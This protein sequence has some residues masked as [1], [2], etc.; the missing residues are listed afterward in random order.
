M[1]AWRQPLRIA[2]VLFVCGV[3]AAVVFGLR[4]RVETAPPAVVERSDPDAVIQTRGSRLVQADADGENLR[5]VS[6]IQ[7]T[8]PDGRLRLIG[9]V[10]ATVAERAERG[11]FVLTGDEAALDADQSGVELTGGVRME[12]SDGLH[13]ETETASYADTD[14]IVRMP[15]PTTFHDV[16]LDAAGESAEYDR[17]RALL[18]LLSSARVDLLGDG[19]RT[20][21]RSAT[22]TLAQAESY[23]QFAGDVAVD[24]GTLRMTA[25]RARAVLV[26]E[27]SELESLELRDDAR[28][29]A[30]EPTPGGLRDLG[31]NTMNLEYVP[32]ESGRRLDH[33]VLAGGAH[34]AVYAADG[35]QGSEIT[36]RSMELSF[37]DGGVLTGL[38]ARDEVELALP[39]GDSSE[40]ASGSTIRGQSME[41]AFG[42]DGGLGGLVARD[43]VEFELPHGDAS[44]TQV[45]TANM[46]TVT[47]RGEEG[48]DAALFEG[49]VT[50][51]EVTRAPDGD[52]RSR[53]TDAERMETMLTPG[54]TRLEEARFIGRVRF[55]DGDRVGESDEALYSVAA[56]SVTL[57]T[58]ESGQRVPRVI[59]HRGAVQAGAVILQLDGGRIEAV[60]DVKSVLAKTE[61]T[62]GEASNEATR[63][64]GLLDADEEVSVVAG[65]LVYDRETSVATYSG[66][67]R[68]WQRNASFE[69]NEITLDEMNG[70][71]DAAGGVRTRSLMNQ[72]NDDTGLLEEQVTTGEAEQFAFDESLHRATYSERARLTGPRAD[73]RA[74]LITLFLQ[75]DSRTL[76]RIEAEGSVELMMTGRRVAGESLVYFD[77]DGRYEMEGAPVRL[78]EEIEDGCRDTTGRNL[79][80][81]MTEEAV[82][83]DGES[84]VRTE[85]ITGECPEATLGP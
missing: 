59:D 73:M 75:E 47:G 36:G 35:G 1:A 66:R 84:E 79:T 17:R 55:D 23:M 65:Q 63:R 9:N 11:G 67:A 71:L 6:D 18:R 83:V 72:I 28:I 49:N 68:L 26:D 80:F 48:L 3:G 57:L 56:G 70:D 53:R 37:A 60:D 15:V 42:D 38:V 78:T 32:S 85:T 5:V 44:Q 58:S 41:L 30:A 81:F 29:A 27:S 74:D 54:L 39:G 19:N 61:G 52:A 7:S 82:S 31:S 77:A 24:T 8:Y 12:A 40:T 69:G 51:I 34:A 20:Q 76:E 25:D 45:V 16:G 33:A 13:A 4:Q 50:Y 46:V 43:Q 62:P 21:I 14:G 22:A 10:Q 2:L 64:P